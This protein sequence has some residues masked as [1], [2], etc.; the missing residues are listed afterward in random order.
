LK[1]ITQMLAIGLFASFTITGCHPSNNNHLGDIDSRYDSNTGIIDGTEIKTTDSLQRELGIV[2]ILIYKDD[3]AESMCTGTL[4]SR[5]TIVTAAHC[6][7]GQQPDKIRVIF[8][9][10]ISSY[11]W[12][13]YIYP[14]VQNNVRAVQSLQTHPAYLDGKS[15]S[16]GDIA[17]IHL[18]SDAPADYQ[19]AEPLTD[20]SL[21]T[22][23]EKLLVAGFG[24]NTDDA[25]VKD[26]GA[27]VLRQG[28]TKVAEK[29]GSH[30]FM[31]Q[32]EGRGTCMGDSGGPI[33]YFDKIQNKYLYV[34]VISSV[35]FQPDVKAVCHA[36][37]IGEVFADHQTW[38]DL[39]LL[40]I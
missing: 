22:E 34:G 15:G 37:A 4:I 35:S 5:N 40:K 1:L 7:Y 17:M 13:K 11:T 32:K 19:I 14:N 3:V 2:V 28:E 30:L 8:D 38:I 12:L 20:T 29:K 31:N 9:V 6:V 26:S 21:L 23:N 16:W 36:Q 18:Q 25:A 39:A 27:G 10:S 33:Y 24:R